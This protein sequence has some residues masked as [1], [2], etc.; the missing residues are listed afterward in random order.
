MT[1]LLHAAGLTKRFGGLVANDAVDLD[2]GE[3][4][5]HAVIGPNGAGKT[6]LLAQLSGELSPD[7]GSIHFGG[8]EITAWPVAA[9][10]RLGLARSFQIT[11][12][13][14]SFTV[15]DN[16]ALAVQ[17]R[18][19]HSFKFW[20]NAARDPALNAPAAKAL[21]RVGLAAHADRPAAALA[22]GQKRRLELAMALAMRP[23]LL[24][25]DEP[26]AGMGGEESAEMVTLLAG[27]RSQAPILLVEHDM[28]A[29]F[30]LADRITVLLHG[31]V[32]ASGPPAAI[33]ADTRV[34]EAYLG[35]DAANGGA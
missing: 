18:E 35:D 28:D 13:L 2:V 31:R 20:R 4:E 33:R 24:L 9:R 30:A 29:V 22:H 21:D 6:T 3:G 14:P 5:I 15:R 25:L 23:K 12:I 17:G 1:A 11:T 7:A 10:A 26:M 8:R 16:V 19:R 34:R 27:L 32:I